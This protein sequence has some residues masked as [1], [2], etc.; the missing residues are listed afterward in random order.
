MIELLTANTPNGR[1]SI[2]LEEMG[3]EFKIKIDINKNEQFKP[4]LKISPFS[5]YP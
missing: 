3:Y 5:K 1:K 4:N 2:M